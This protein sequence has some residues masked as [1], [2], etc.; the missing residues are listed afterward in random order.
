[1]HLET[2][3]YHSIPRPWAVQGFAG[4][5]QKTITTKSIHGASIPSAPSRRGM[6]LPTPWRL[7]FDCSFHFQSSSTSSSAS[8]LP[9][10]LQPHNNT[11][12]LTIAQHGICMHRYAVHH[13][14]RVVRI[15]NA[16][17]VGRSLPRSSPPLTHTLN[18]AFLFPSNFLLH[19]PTYF[20]L[21][22]EQISRP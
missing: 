4:W 13:Q 15:E 12:I 9:P 11:H 17:Q 10:S 21:C 20:T 7:L 14:V 6:Y 22:V 5:R 3:N 18:A 19:S 1:M 16:A 2:Y 8:S